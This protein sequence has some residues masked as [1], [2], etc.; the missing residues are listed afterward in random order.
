MTLEDFKNYFKLVCLAH[1]DIKDFKVGSDYN[2]SEDNSLNFPLA[3]LE[4][5]YLVNY[6]LASEYDTMNCALNIHFK[7]GINDNILIDHEGSA[8]LIDFDRGEGSVL[9]RI[10]WRGDG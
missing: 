3:F 9:Y 10:I 8:F 7:A 4:M 5:S 2:Q 1:R 6:S